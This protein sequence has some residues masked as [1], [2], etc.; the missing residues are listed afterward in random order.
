MRSIIG[1]LGFKLGK[2]Y[3]SD[4]ENKDYAIK[5]I[6][7][8]VLK[9]MG[10]I[11]IK[12]L[13]VLSVTH[14]FMDGWSTPKEY[15]VFNQVKTEEINLENYVD[16]KNFKYIEETP[17]AS[18]SFAQV[19]KA[20][21]NTHE[22]VI[23]KVLKPSV[24]E[25]LSSDLKKLKRIIKIISKFAKN[26]MLD[27]KVAF[28]AFAEN[29]LLETDYE[30]EIANLE[31]FQ[32]IY[33][34][35]TYVVIPKVYKDLSNK[36][37]IVEEYIEG[38][39]LADVITNYNYN[40]AF[41]TYTSNITGSNIWK[42]LA[43]IG[44]ECLRCAMSEDYV[45]GDPHP[46]NIILLSNDK[47][48]IIDF[49]LIACKPTSQEAFYLWTKAYNNILNGSPDYGSLVESTCMCFCPDLVN[50]LRKCDMHNDFFKSMADAINVKASIIRGSNELAN[51]TIEDGHL[52]TAFTDFIDNTNALNLKVDMKNFQLLKAIQAFVCSVT[53]IDNRFNKHI[54][55]ELMKE[56]MKYALDYVETKGIKKDLSNKTKYTLNESYELLL[57]SLSQ[58]ASNDEFLFKEMCE[59]MFL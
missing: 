17:F 27:Y 21:L 10:G 54:Y 14:K 37:V 34:N 24:T 58:L 41:D 49:G 18:G 8:D 26:S 32:N 50:A 11:Y 46:G 13:Q 56:S 48:A 36:K 59:R 39:T 23:I 19:Y 51:K 33:Q 5:R 45:F 29:S 43:I 3:F 9:D 28:D 38:P 53:S 12:F 4:I 1:K 57:D 22:K 44:G 55:A 25:N 7:F 40:E 20:E 6:I 16:K 35:H 15:S 42:Q 52:F 47:V 31:Y 30:R 2:V